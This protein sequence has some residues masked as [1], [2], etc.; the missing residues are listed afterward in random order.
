MLSFSCLHCYLEIALSFNTIDYFAF[1]RS[2][3]GSEAAGD[4]VLIQTSL[5]LCKCGLVSITTTATIYMIKTVRS[6]I[7]TRPPAAGCHSTVKWL[8]L[9]IRKI[10]VKGQH[11][12][13]SASFLQANA[14]CH[15]VWKTAVYRTQCLEPLPHK[16]FT[17]PPE[18]PG[19]TSA[20]LEETEEPGARAR[21]TTNSGFRWT[22]EQT[23]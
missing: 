6:C 5:H 1:T 8:I 14:I 20:A 15:L 16:T 18:M 11:F 22:L 2:I 3:D 17:A 19:F 13:A 7:N 9:N 4:L 10:N 12:L 23:R 21:E